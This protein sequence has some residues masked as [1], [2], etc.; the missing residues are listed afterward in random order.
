MSM[1]GV[2]S[3]WIVSLVELFSFFGGTF[4]QQLF[5]PHVYVENILIW[6]PG[7]N[8]HDVQMS[9][10]VNDPSSALLY[11]LKPDVIRN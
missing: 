4:P 1:Y 8:Y 5:I 11:C 10:D 2:T 9:L 7:Y 6:A 3:F